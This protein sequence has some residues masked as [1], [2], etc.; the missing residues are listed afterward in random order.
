MTK[1]IER[2]KKV[3]DERALVPEINYNPLLPENYY[4]LNSKEKLLVKLLNKYY[5][6]YI[7]NLNILDVGFGSGLDFLTFIKLGADIDGLF[8]VEILEERYNRV[9]EIIPRINLLLT[10]DFSLPFEDKS[11]DI[12]TQST[13]L[14][15][16]LDKNCRTQLAFEMY[17]VLK[18]GG[19]IFSY[20]IRYSNPWNPNVIKIDK[21]EIHD[22]FPSAITSFYPVT[23]NPVITRKIAPFS[24]LLCEILGFGFLCS[25]YYSVLEKK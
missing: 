3:Y 1:E 9:K 23:L 13:V 19:R 25:H 16:I 12:I 6:P 18:P 10:N 4:L 21:K 2:I 17:R 14:S 20:D 15:S 7:G 11:M 22:L 24:I 8:G 5:G